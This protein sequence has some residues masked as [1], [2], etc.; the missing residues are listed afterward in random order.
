MSF[1]C[2]I[3][4]VWIKE[5]LEIVTHSDNVKHVYGTSYNVVYSTEQ[6]KHIQEQNKKQ[7]PQVIDE[8]YL[9]RMS[10]LFYKFMKKA[11][12]LVLT[13]FLFL[14][15]GTAVGMFFYYVYLHLQASV[16]GQQ[17]AFLKREDLMF[18][19]RTLFGAKAPKGQEVEAHYFGTI[20]ENVLEFMKEVNIELLY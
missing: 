10:G 14:V 19:G 17:A 6:L 15:L 13:Y 18:T 4:V 3:F 5:N 11:F 1:F 12:R 7:K 16:A 9:K 2:A 20:K 8:K